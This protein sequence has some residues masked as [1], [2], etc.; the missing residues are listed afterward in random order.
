MT[1]P[2]RWPACAAARSVDSYLVVDAVATFVLQLVAVG[3]PDPGQCISS[4]SVPTILAY[5]ISVA[6]AGLSHSRA[7]RS[8]RAAQT[9]RH[10]ALVAHPPPP[11]ADAAAAGAIAAEP[12]VADVG[13]VVVA[14][15]GGFQGLDGDFYSE[16]DGDPCAAYGLALWSS[17][18]SLFVLYV[19]VAALLEDC[20]GLFMKVWHGLSALLW[21]TRLVLVSVEEVAQLGRYEVLAG[22]A[23]HAAAA[24]AAAAAE[25]AE[26]EAAEIERAEDAA[27]IVDPPP[28]PRARRQGPLEPEEIDGLPITNFKSAVDYSAKLRLHRLARKSSVSASKSR[29]VPAH[30][31]PSLADSRAAPLLAAPSSL[32]IATSSPPLAVAALSPP[33]AAPSPAPPAIAA[34]P[35]PPS[36]SPTPSLLPFGTA[37]VPVPTPSLLTFGAVTPDAPLPLASLACLAAS[38]YPVEPGTFP[39][40]AAD[41]PDPLLPVTLTAPLPALLPVPPTIAASPCIAR[42]TLLPPSAEASSRP[43]PPPPPP[44]SAEASASSLPLPQSAVASSCR[45]PPPPS[46]AP[47]SQRVASLVGSGMRMDGG[48]DLAWSNGR[49]EVRVSIAHVTLPMDGGTISRA[50]DGVAADGPTLSDGELIL[51]MCRTRRPTTRAAAVPGVST[52]LHSGGALADLPPGSG[53]SIVAQSM[54]SS[55]I[56]P[57]GSGP[58]TA[59]QSMSSSIESQGGHR[60]AALSGEM[61]DAERTES[62]R[63]AICLYAFTEPD[64]PVKQLPRCGHY[65]HVHCIEQWLSIRNACPSCVQTVILRP[66]R[67]AS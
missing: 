31:H 65:F 24:A 55:S 67:S 36:A 49:G 60:T 59:T 63:C 45:P 27:A 17:A 29:A 12:A 23:A 1:E 40:P 54:S 22:A 61:V 33:A 43:P 37:P 26:A 3:S 8:F 38:A 15:V 30:R 66:S 47:S 50:G 32:A 25:A 39:A 35:C 44:P 20:V 52:P 7:E 18:G 42:P 11:A 56:G 64:E 6:L 13:A 4:V 51:H 62:E 19:A 9:H 58:A 5:A 48:V 34:L 41:R 57:P 46:T 28:A 16:S 21:V 2:R 10:P 53:P 14:D